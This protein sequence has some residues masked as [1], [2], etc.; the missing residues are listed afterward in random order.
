[1]IAP[2]L[3][4]QE[5]LH[6]FSRDEY[7]RMVRAGV[8][9]EDEHLELL[10][11]VIF[12]MSPQLAAHAVV[13]QAL[14]RLIAPALGQRGWLR[15]QLPLIAGDESEPEPDLAVVPPGDYAERH[16][17]RA[18]WVIEVAAES[19]RKDRHIKGPLYAASGF[20]EYWIVNLV[21]KVVEAHRGPEGDAWARITR[22][23]QGETIA[24]EAFP[25]LALA[26]GDFLR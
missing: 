3:L 20:A 8:F 12:S 2:H 26:I 13:I 24:P 14:T 10:H 15:V 21:D 17:G 4:A 19:L 5:R 22:H 16:P 18:L 1:V 9:D 23:G 11:G 6:R 7:D 25:D